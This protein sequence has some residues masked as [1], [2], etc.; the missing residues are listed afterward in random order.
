M[1]EVVTVTLQTKQGFCLDFDLPATIPLSK[2]YPRL[3]AVLQQTGNACFSGW[4]Q[5]FLQTH[6]GVLS[7]LDATLYDY[8]ICRGQYLTIIQGEECSWHS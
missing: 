1:S 4:N 3:L 7:D 6:E 5:L 2:L 8:G